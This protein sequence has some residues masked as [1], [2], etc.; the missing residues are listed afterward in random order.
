MNSLQRFFGLLGLVLITSCAGGGLPGLVEGQR[1]VEAKQQLEKGADPSVKGGTRDLA[2]IDYALINFSSCDSDEC[3][4][5]HLELIKY[6][7]SLGAV[8]TLEDNSK[9]MSPTVTSQLFGEL[10]LSHTKGEHYEC[11]SKLMLGNLQPTFTELL[12]VGDGGSKNPE[13]LPQFIK[14]LASLGYRPS[15]E[16]VDEAA[17][18]FFK[19]REWLSGGEVFLQMCLDAGF[20]PNKDIVNAANMAPDC[21]KPLFLAAISGNAGLRNMIKPLLEN[22]AILSGRMYDTLYDMPSK[23]RHHENSA[24]VPVFEDSTSELHERLYTALATGAWVLK[25]WKDEDFI[26]KYGYYAE[27]IHPGLNNSILLNRELLGMSNAGRESNTRRQEREGRIQAL[28]D[29]EA[30]VF[31]STFEF[32]MNRGDHNKHFLVSAFRDS[33]SELYSLYHSSLSSALSNQATSGDCGRFLGWF[34]FY[35]EKLD[36]EIKEEVQQK[37]VVLKLETLNES[38][39][40]Q[41]LLEAIDEYWEHRQAITRL[42]YLL[43][44]YRAIQITEENRH[45]HVFK[46]KEIFGDAY[47]EGMT[48]NNGEM[49]YSLALDTTK[50]DKVPYSSMSS[51]VGSM[52][53]YPDGIPISFNDEWHPIGGCL[54]RGWGSAKKEGLL[55]YAGAFVLVPK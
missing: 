5:E 18:G 12:N 32:L 34:G 28:L 30:W 29:S 35:A 7:D 13:R 9:E 50:L 40:E 21:R 11:L 24:F 33:T 4:E 47:L 6:L 16:E 49:E 36:P 14:A 19:K 27:K 37:Y 51:I 17:H 26:D 42:V 55:P 52:R 15:S 45:E 10:V 20:D 48:A 8:F 39:G 38:S 1:I 41:E 44:D 3:R 25:S 23:R 31:P 53:L 2:A 43:R 54:F 46:Y 22:G